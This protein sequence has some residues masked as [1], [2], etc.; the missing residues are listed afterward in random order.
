MD[1]D[2]DGRPLLQRPW[3]WVTAALVIV[4]AVLLT[5]VLIPG[6]DDEEP[7]AADPSAS[8]SERLPLPTER[9]ETGGDVD[10]LG[11]PVVVPSQRRG[12]PLT[13]SES[14]SST[15]DSNPLARPK[16]LEWQ[17]VYGAPA[18]FSR[19]DGPVAI[20]DEGIPTGMSHT[21][22]GA[23]IAGLQIMSRM[24][25][26][27]KNERYAVIAQRIIGTDTD[28]AGLRGEGDVLSF[29]I[30]IPGVGDVAAEKVLVPAAF[31]IRPGNWSTDAAT[32]DLAYGPHQV[33][34]SDDSD[35]L[36]SVYKWQSISVL[37]VN[38]EWSLKFRPSMLTKDT[39]EGQI[40]S[41][42]G[43]EWATWIR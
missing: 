38:G 28:K 37:W 16:G 22:Q 19:S 9:P 26:G 5:I 25:F 2:L 32:I 33:P 30:D 10:D 36:H 21:P 42:D 13:Q 3:V 34:V 11:R 31:R 39:E 35:E 29:G 23:T 4:A 40:A 17:R 6:D 12:V 1:D 7:A 27:P 8:S 18:P 14:T 24:F 20:T 43:G 41:L 15:S